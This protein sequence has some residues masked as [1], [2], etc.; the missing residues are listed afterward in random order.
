MCIRDRSRL[1]LLKKIEKTEKELQGLAN[2]KAILLREIV[3]I[4]S[5]N[6]PDSGQEIVDADEI[7]DNLQR[8]IDL[9]ESTEEVTQEAIEVQVQPSG[10]SEVDF[11]ELLILQENMLREKVRS[12]QLYS[13]G[14]KETG[15][16]VDA[17]IR[18]RHLMQLT[19]HINT[20]Q[21]SEFKYKEKATDEHQNEIESVLQNEEKPNTTYDSLDEIFAEI[22]DLTDLEGKV[23]LQRNR[24]E[25]EQET[26][27][28]QLD[29]VIRQS[30]TFG[31]S[32][33]ADNFQ[34][35]SI[36]RKRGFL[37][38]P[39]ENPQLIERLGP[40]TSGSADNSGIK[41]K[42]DNSTVS[43]IYEGIVEKLSTD[44]QGLKTIIV[45]HDER[46]LSHYTGLTSVLVQENDTVNQH[47]KLGD[48]TGLMHFE[49]RQNN[50]IQ[51]PLHWLQNN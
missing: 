27:N 44:G 29:A 17:M 43:C 33:A 5:G 41:I 16:L 40:Q 38:W 47:Q 49:I 48:C 3:R 50:S 42:S 30:S 37:P 23:R 9:N 22:S 15:K 31:A 14:Y 6:T 39:L 32:T 7:D 46:T 4:E 1:E 25:R 36:I 12:E 28:L 20:R 8:L 26:I 35:S 18:E 51:N 21:N 2:K 11:S 19:S 10:Y 45:R 34:A 13:D 24:L